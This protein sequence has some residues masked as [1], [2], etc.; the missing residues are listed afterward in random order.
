LTVSRQG[1]GCDGV[2]QRKHTITRQH[3]AT[4]IWRVIEDGVTA[5]ATEVAILVDV[6]ID[7]YRQVSIGVDHGIV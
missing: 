3:N 4:R 5:L 6:I 1:R 2:N 7:C